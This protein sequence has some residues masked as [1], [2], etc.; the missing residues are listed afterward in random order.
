LGDWWACFYRGDCEE[1]DDEL[2]FAQHRVA[3]K[4]V[5]EPDETPS[6]FFDEQLVGSDVV[7][8]DGHAFGR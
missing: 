2:L 7:A 8:I 4:S 3:D 1:H 5:D 6:A